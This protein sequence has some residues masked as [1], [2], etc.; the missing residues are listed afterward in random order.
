MHEAGAVADEIL[1][2]RDV[3]HSFG[4]LRVLQSVSFAL[5]KGRVLGLIGPNGSG[6]TTLFNIVTGYL[7]PLAGMLHYDGNSLDNVPV[8]QRSRTGLVRTFQTPKI[9]EEMSVLENVMAGCCKTTRTGILGDLLRSPKSRQEYRH[10]REVAEAACEKFGLT[11]IQNSLARNT[12]AGQRRIIELARATVGK[13]R[14][15]LLD[16]PSAGLNPQE[17]EQLRGW[18][19]RLNSEGLSILLVS[20]DMSLMTVAETVHVLYF[21]GIIATGSM[22]DIQKNARVREVYLG[23]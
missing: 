9:F 3:G 19:M 11:T 4:G 18:I 23:V 22:S 14:L 13:P 12:T 15:L 21:G 2:L 1:E 8:Q 16:E 17:I 20:H 5:P 7:K 6:K 10:M